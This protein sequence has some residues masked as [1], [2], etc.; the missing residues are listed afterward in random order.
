M[1]MPFGSRHVPAR[2]VGPAL[3]ASIGGRAAGVGRC[4]AGAQQQERCGDRDGVQQVARRVSTPF[5]AISVGRL[6]V[7]AT[8]G[9]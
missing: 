4:D 1:A 3:V 6:G 8:A 9:A 5:R 7:S 2:T